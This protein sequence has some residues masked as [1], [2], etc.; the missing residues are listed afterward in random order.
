MAQIIASVS[1]V[2]GV[3]YVKHP[4]GSQVQLH[5]GDKIYEGDI[6]IGEAS[7]NPMNNIII[8][9]QD[10]SE[11]IMLA[12]EEQLFDAS[13][14]Q[15]AFS[16][17]ETVTDIS[18]VTALA[19]ME[20]GEDNT[21]DDIVQPDDMETAAGDDSGS[22]SSDSSYTPDFQEINTDFLDQDITTKL[23][24]IDTVSN[25]NEQPDQVQ[26][27]VIPATEESSAIENTTPEIINSS[28]IIVNEDNLEG[29][30]GFGATWAGDVYSIITQAEMLNHL[31]IHD[32]DSSHF[33]VALAHTD[34]GNNY[35]KAPSATDAVF[36][37]PTTNHYDE[38]V[39]QVTQEFL[40]LYP[41]IDA[42]VGD[43]YFDNVEFDKLG[44]GD[45]ANITFAVEVSDGE[46]V[47]E[48]KTVEIRVIGS[49][50]APTIDIV[51]ITATEDIAQV[52]ANASD[53]DGTI[54]TSSMSA[55]H[56]RLTLQ[57]NGD[58]LY[59]PDHNFNGTD[60]ISISITDNSGATTTQNF[61][62]N[63][64]SVNDVPTLTVSPVE[65]IVED[66]VSAGTIIATTAVDDVEG[67]TTLLEISDTEHYMI[68]DN[69]DIALT[70][71]GAAVV[72]VG[73]DLPDYSVTVHEVTDTTA[74]S[75]TL[76]DTNTS[77]ITIA[78][79]PTLNLNGKENFE[80]SLAV[81]PDGMQGNYDIIF[82]K[83]S[84]VE[85]AFT[86][87]GHLQFAMRTTDEGWVWHKTDVEYN[88]DALNNITFK[89]DGEH[90][91]ITN[92]G[93]D[94][95]TDT[96]VQNYTGSIIDY[97]N[98]L[99]IGN[100]PYGN[101][102]YS[103][104]GDVDNIAVTIDGKEALH[105]DF[106]G[107]NPLADSS[108]N[109]NDAVL[110]A[111]VEIHRTF[112]GEGVSVDVM[113]V[114][115][116]DVNDAPIAVDEIANNSITL[117]DTNTSNITIADS[118]TLNL[119]GKENFEL[120]LAVTPDGMQGNYDIIFNKESTVELAFTNDGHLQFAMRTT[121][122]G[123]VWHKTDVEYNADAL[124]N[125]TFK[126]DGEHVT[127]TN[128]GEDGVTDTYVQNYT[129]SIIDYGNDLMIGNRP[130]GNGK[131][132]MDGDVD[133][134]AVTID[135][136]E[137]LHL[138]FQGQN[139]LADS[140][141]N[142][143]DAVLGASAVLHEGEGIVTDEDHSVTIDALANDTDEEGD[144]LSITEIQG[145]DV[146]AGQTVNI[147]STDGSDM[148]LGT[149][150]VVSGKINF[151]PS[152]TLQQ[153]NKGENQDVTFNYTVSD[154]KGGEDTANITVN[155]TGSD[156]AVVQNNYNVGDGNR[157]HNTTNDLSGED[158]T[159]YTNVVGNVSNDTIIG[160]EAV[161]N[162]DGGSGNDNITGTSGDDTIVGGAGWDTLK[163][164]A[165][166]DTFRVNGTNNG[167]DTIIGGEGND[168]ILGGDADD[169]IGLKNFEAGAVENIDGGAGTNTIQVGDGNRWHNTSSDFSETNISNVD[170]IKGTASNDTIIGNE[171]VH[172]YDGGSGN[173]NITGTSGDDTIVGGAGWDTLKGGAGDDTFRVNGT[174]NGQDT[175]IG[176]EGNDTI[177]GGDADDTIGLK[178]FEAGAVENIDGG[179]GTNTI[180]VGDGNRWH[181]T[182]S[183]FSETNIS[184]VDAIKGTA[185]ND[186][187]IGNEAVHNYDGGSG[188][189][190][191]TG[192]SG[193]DTIVGGAGWDTLKGGAGDDTFRVNG[194]NN[195]QDTIIGG[196]GNDT[197]LGG[198]ADD[199]I[200][201]KNFEAGAVENIDGGAGTNTIQVGDGNRWHN[202]SSDFSETNISNVDAIKGTASNDTIIGNEAVHNYDGGSGNDNITGTSGDDTIVGG[203]GW[204]TLKGGAGDDT[205]RVNGTNNG[206]DTI[207]GGEGNDTILGGDADDTI[208]LKNFEAGAVENIDG[209]AGTNTIQVG[210]GNRWHNTSSDFSETN[211]SNVDAIK[212]TASN[213][214]IIGNEA[215]H[216]YDGGSGN[217][218]I[219]GTSGDDTIVGG[220]GS[221][222]INAGAGDDTIVLDIHDAM[223]NGGEGLDTL[224]ASKDM[225]IDLSALSDSISNIETIN[226]D[227]GSQNITS[228]HVEDVLDMTDSDNILRIDGTE[229]DSVALNTKGDDAEW[230]LGDFQTTDETTGETYDVYEH[231][232]DDGSMVTIEIDT[233]I[234]VDES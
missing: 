140:S 165:G 198:D 168:T 157:W 170:A 17:D 228:L 127:I 28:D 106:Q 116:T 87:D 230:K 197:I 105:L 172:N 121:D 179:A 47:S 71:K 75:V 202:T 80:L 152:E 136:K 124:N 37:N 34:G 92:T 201:L 135:G 176:G 146:S 74:S 213:D 154:G 214:T 14:T 97:G 177:L 137:A 86:N 173:D 130:Y 83:E 122:E 98:D 54:D 49:N 195:G 76:S 225:S 210:D 36:S 88:A 183:D 70:A 104:D 192:T 29:F 129:G 51:D 143:N 219:T 184:N 94:G 151:T 63:V 125:I 221:D 8:S 224:I 33:T 12:D 142:G 132:S 175:I 15:E 32:S 222:R 167:Q 218:N 215:V 95:V 205:F 227:E 13:L 100:R 186:T 84:T 81:T 119:N 155:V 52:I 217:D 163:G 159:G 181:N 190:N 21:T 57:D 187:I 99:M 113:P 107:Q 72:N 9:M 206:Q 164:G 31:N 103:M 109:G 211:I 144:A 212:G 85:L 208:G 59:T 169:T 90:V 77:N 30:R 18:A 11:M 162:Y 161:H 234:Q 117:S 24:D 48:P 27:V 38:T 50:D 96:Y 178:N 139:P 16:A 229:E 160:N 19:E 20:S 191:I 156:D 67:D 138:D 45:I 3:F 93:E 158:L 60:N 131:Y 58:I 123:W 43:F 207:I 22:A 101:G 120:S 35:F 185:S 82:N 203:A 141:G 189:D 233:H 44:E 4:D 79:S 226:L 110:G 204:D 147:M 216:N 6:V 5:E 26:R 134:I 10:G 68:N 115:T 73:Q 69:G 199:T 61:T 102:K 23:R 65:S 209:G 126:Y 62:V 149:A 200:G 39:V 166:D 182:S 188:N 108:G 128:T 56:G 89:Y 232:N 55:E 64:A 41:Q 194:T 133:N 25:A 53:I 91:T 40:D 174:N 193:D 180:Q 114:A 66:S 223:I 150:A 46:H 42:Q 171:A 1:S 78:D 231:Q 145:Q 220:A 196:E 2:N 7:N 112:E 148:L 153:M 118:P 111:G